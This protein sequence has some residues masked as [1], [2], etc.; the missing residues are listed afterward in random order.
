MCSKHVPEAIIS[1]SFSTHKH[2]STLKPHVHVHVCSQCTSHAY[3]YSCVHVVHCTCKH[4]FS[5]FYITCFHVY[6][7]TCIYIVIYMYIHVAIVQ[8]VIHMQYIRCIYVQ[9][10]IE[11]NSC[12]LVK[13]LLSHAYTFTYSLKW[14]CAYILINFLIILVC[15]SIQI[16]TF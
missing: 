6:A 8:V 10:L 15:A 9:N 7:C 4:V 5:I 2:T 11:P 14:E 16:D 12:S 1:E 3:M 13:I